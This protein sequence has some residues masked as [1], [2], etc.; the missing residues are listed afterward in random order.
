MIHM[1]ESHTNLSAMGVFRKSSVVLFKP[2]GQTSPT[3]GLQ[4]MKMTCMETLVFVAVLLSFIT[5]FNSLL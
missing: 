3:P 4:C 1:V 5:T 2:R